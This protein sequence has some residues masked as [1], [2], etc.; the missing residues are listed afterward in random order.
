MAQ[1]GTFQ[2]HVDGEWHT[3][4]KRIGWTYAGAQCDGCGQAD[5]LTTD[6][7]EHGDEWSLVCDDCGDRS[8]ERQYSARRN[9]R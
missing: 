7:Y 1:A 4:A 9:Y 6:Y 2:V 5:G 8:I 3:V